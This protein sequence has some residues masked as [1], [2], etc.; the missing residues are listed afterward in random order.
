[1]EGYLGP[2]AL[3]VWSS[4]GERWVGL[5]HYRCHF[6]DDKIQEQRDRSFFFFFFLFKI[7]QLVLN[8]SRIIGT[9]SW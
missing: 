2:K 4:H 9:R 3:L 6:T 5:W 7:T 1:M 8:G